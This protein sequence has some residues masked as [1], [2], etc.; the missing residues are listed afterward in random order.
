MADTY[1]IQVRIIIRKDLSDDQMKIIDRVVL[2]KG[3]LPD[4]LP[5]HLFFHYSNESPDIFLVYEKLKGSAFNSGL[6]YSEPFGC[7]VTLDMQSIKGTD[8]YYRILLFIDWL[9][10]IA[11][12]DQFVGFSSNLKDMENAELF[13][14]KNKK[15]YIFPDFNDTGNKQVVYDE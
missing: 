8:E 9:S 11:D 5:E 1:S 12:S 3:S 4:L 13:F 14:S 6:F 10:K 15:L 2:G 7:I